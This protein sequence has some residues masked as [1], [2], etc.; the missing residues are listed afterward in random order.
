MVSNKFR[1]VVFFGVAALWIL[2]GV[3][4][5]FFK[6]SFHVYLSTLIL[7]TLIMIWFISWKRANVVMKPGWVRIINVKI[8]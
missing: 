7:G 2:W 8:P 6:N 3:V 1:G 5:Y 4:D